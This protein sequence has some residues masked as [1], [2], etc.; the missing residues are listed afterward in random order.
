ML[1]QNNFISRTPIRD[2]VTNR[3]IGWWITAVTASCVNCCSPL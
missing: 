3:Q 1:N 2:S